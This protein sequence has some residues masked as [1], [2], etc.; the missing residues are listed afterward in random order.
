MI[1]N[2]PSNR[3][4][5][6]QEQQRMNPAEQNAPSF[7][8]TLNSSLADGARQ[9]S[10]ILSAFLKSLTQNLEGVWTRALDNLFMDG[11]W[12]GRLSEW[13]EKLPPTPPGSAG[14]EMESESAAEG[15]EGS[16]AALLHSFSDGAQETSAQPWVYAGLLL[17]VGAVLGG[18]VKKRHT[19]VPV[20]SP[21]E[22]NS[23]R[24]G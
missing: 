10:T 23:Q 17:S 20:G 9:S 16:N 15:P 4:E 1:L 21:W 22:P 18:D 14:E 6:E 2:Q 12:Q 19:S 8:R 5:S 3:S 7:T 13:L 11:H 24:L